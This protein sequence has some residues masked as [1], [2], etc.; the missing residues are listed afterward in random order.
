MSQ[1]AAA[2]IFSQVGSGITEA[3]K[4]LVASEDRVRKPTRAVE[5]L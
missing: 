5:S 4:I 1:L 3:A 2:L